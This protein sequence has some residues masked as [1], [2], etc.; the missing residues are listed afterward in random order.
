MGFFYLVS[1]KA[2]QSSHSSSQGTAVAAFFI[3][4]A[5][6]LLLYLGYRLDARSERIKKEKEEAAAKEQAAKEQA[7]KEQA[8]K[9]Q[10]A[11][12]TDAPVGI[13]REL[14][15]P[16]E[17]CGGA[18]AKGFSLCP[19]CLE[20]LGKGKLIKCMHC[21]RWHGAEDTCGCTERAD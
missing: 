5:L 3:L 17:A 4:G 16:C 2:Q 13:D 9:E 11:A 19:A 20:L 18:T 10:A 8:A 15:D 1:V 21:G 12:P 6:L 7:A 14:F